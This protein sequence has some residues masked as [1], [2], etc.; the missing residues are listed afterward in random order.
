M[1]LYCDIV[2]KKAFDRAPYLD[3]IELEHPEYGTISILFEET[4]RAK[5]D[6][7]TYAYRMKGVSFTYLDDDSE[8]V[9]I[10]GNNRMDIVKN[11]KL[12]EVGVL[13]A[14]DNEFEYGKDFTFKDNTMLFKD[15]D[16]EFK[17]NTSD[18]A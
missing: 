6:D 16:E 14:D 18:L 8:E 4:D 7:L 15:G 9:E 5:T 13:D 12:I 1:N 2:T 11:S 17:L 3:I 10:Y